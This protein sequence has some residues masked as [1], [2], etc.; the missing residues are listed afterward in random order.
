MFSRYFKLI[1][2]MFIVFVLFGCG[3]KHGVHWGYTGDH[4][5]QHWG[6][7]DS[8]YVLCKKGKNQSPINVQGPVKD[9][10]GEFKISYGDAGFSLVNNGHTIKADIKGDSFISVH[11]EKFGLVQ[12][13]FHTPSEHMVDGKPFDMV[14]HFVHKNAKGKL[15]VVGLTFRKGNEN[16]IL[17]TIWA[18]LPKKQGEISKIEGIKINLNNFLPEKRD[19]FA[20]SGSLTTPPC[21][22]GVSWF[23]LKNPVS[24][25]Q[26]QIQAFTA[27][28]SKSVRP[29]QNLN[30]R[31]IYTK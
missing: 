8:A 17:K 3:K 31:N 1:F 20:Y 6:D 30:S 4:G 26:A 19:F 13:H 21:S 27:I 23:V 16:T 28:F 5:P 22:E 24:A 25:T 2:S 15:A 29:V 7:L 18:H 11:G 14:A 12:F 9:Y 10:K